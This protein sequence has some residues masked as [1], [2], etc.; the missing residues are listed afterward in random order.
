MVDEP[1]PI[2]QIPVRH[3]KRK[4]KKRTTTRNHI[5]PSICTL[6]ATIPDDCDIVTVSNERSFHRR[7]YPLTPFVVDDD[8]DETDEVNDDDDIDSE[9]QSTVGLWNDRHGLSY[10]QHQQQIQPNHTTV[11]P[12]KAQQQPPSTE[13][14]QSW[15]VSLS[16]RAINLTEI[17]RPPGY[18]N[19]N[20]N[21]N[22]LIEPVVNEFNHT[23]NDIYLV[24]DDDEV[25]NYD[26]H[27][28]YNDKYVDL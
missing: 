20:S 8:D 12:L 13:H 17:L 6:D 24:E 21:R 7:C 23:S 2:S 25:N 19:Y 22:N 10:T 15:I 18:N 28:R 14:V 3:N 11:V 1:L 5:P 9:T 4:I 16:N 27:I 26:N